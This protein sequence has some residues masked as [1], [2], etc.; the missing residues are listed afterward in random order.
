[1]NYKSFILAIIIG[2]LSFGIVT[3]DSAWAAAKRAAA[4]QDM[5]DVDM[6]DAEE[7]D[8]VR[9]VGKLS[10]GR[11]VS[12]KR[13]AVEHPYAFRI[14]KIRAGWGAVG[15]FM[16]PVSFKENRYFFAVIHPDKIRGMQVG[17]LYTGDVALRHAII[18]GILNGL[19]YPHATVGNSI[20][21]LNP[22]PVE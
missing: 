2:A 20:M 6:E 22:Q 16:R 7:A 17:D 15:E 4:D 14:V 12:G 19:E 21:V 13:Q 8:F 3:N 1:M 18:R 10:M 5:D 11:S 9:G